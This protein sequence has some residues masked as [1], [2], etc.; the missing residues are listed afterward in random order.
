M[1]SEHLKICE[2]TLAWRSMARAYLV[3]ELGSVQCE[4]VFRLWFEAGSP[5]PV[6]TFITKYLVDDSPSNPEAPK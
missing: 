2:F 3:D 4:R 6:R 5:E 1:S